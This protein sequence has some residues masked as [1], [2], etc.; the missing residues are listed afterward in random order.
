MGCDEE[1]I[2]ECEPGNNIAVPE[3]I[4]NILS[5]TT[6]RIEY[7]EKKS[8]GFFMKINLDKKQHNFLLTCAHC[9]SQDD[10]DSK[11]KVSIFYG[12]KN[13]EK[14]K[15][16]ELDN[17]KRFIK[18]FEEQK[19]DATI[20][21]ILSEDDIPD[22]RYLYPDLN[23]K[24]GYEQYIENDIY[25]GGFPSVEVN[26]GDRHFSGGK[27]LKHHTDN[28]KCFLHDCAT[29][30]GSSG[31]PLINN[32]QQVIGIHYGSNKLKTH[33]FGVFIGYIID[34][35]ENSKDSLMFHD[36]GELKNNDEKL[37]LKQEDKN[38]N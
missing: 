14:E 37:V 19:I 9:I 31:S 7:G 24:N 12:K 38:K 4:Y 3:Q 34:F 10:I 11:I 5:K 36:K 13:E 21:E 2:K 28:P 17:N 32:T 6:A 25:T 16:I 29:K 35:L 27:L 20:I 30:E 26:K 22:D 15:Q 33:N 8:T 1:Y 18:C 23:Y